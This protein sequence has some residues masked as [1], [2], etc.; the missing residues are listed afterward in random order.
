ML[1]EKNKAAS[2]ESEIDKINDVNERRLE[3]ERRHNADIASKQDSIRRLRELTL[4]EEQL[5]NSKKEYFIQ[6]QEKDTQYQREQNRNESLLAREYLRENRQYDQQR[7][8]DNYNYQLNAYMV[9]NPTQFFMGASHTTPTV[10]YK[11]LQH[12]RI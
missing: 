7:L 4:A 2:L 11:H 9:M 10:Q 12:G 6:K 8:R 5:Q 3:A 1:Q